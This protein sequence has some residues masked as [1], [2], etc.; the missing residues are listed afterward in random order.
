MPRVRISLWR[1]RQRVLVN[2]YIERDAHGLRPGI[3]GTRETP[4]F[5]WL[6]LPSA[7]HRNLDTRAWDGIHFRASS[8]IKVSG[9]LRFLR[10][11]SN[12]SEV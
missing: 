8:V 7:E 9:I 11:F 2:M 10:A 4:A 6:R 1:F 12:S 3:C 5:G